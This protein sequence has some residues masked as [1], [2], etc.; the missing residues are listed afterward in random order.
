MSKLIESRISYVA[1]CLLFAIGI[2]MSLANGGSL[3]TFGTSLLPQ[4][5]STQMSQGPVPPPPPIPKAAPSPIPPPP[6]NPKA[7]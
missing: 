1:V 6:P 2:C 7:A 4:P 3:P 5:A